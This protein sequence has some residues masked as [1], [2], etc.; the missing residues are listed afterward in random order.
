MNEKI[1]K[2]FKL[3]DYDFLGFKTISKDL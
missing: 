2:S 1:K 3:A